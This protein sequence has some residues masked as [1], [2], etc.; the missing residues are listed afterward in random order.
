ML[1]RLFENFV[2]KATD[3]WFR[4][5]AIEWL[6]LKSAFGVLI[7]IFKVDPIV[8]TKTTRV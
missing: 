7:A 1:K 3:W 5:R 8:K 6:L 2:R 4:V